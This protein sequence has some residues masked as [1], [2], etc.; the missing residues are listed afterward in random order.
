MEELQP[1]TMKIQE[2]HITSVI[3]APNGPDLVNKLLTMDFSLVYNHHVH[4]SL[5]KSAV[6][7]QWDGYE[8]TC[9]LKLWGHNAEYWWINDTHFIMIAKTQQIYMSRCSDY[10]DLLK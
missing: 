4:M 7:A 3:N 8:P 6:H 9:R 2:V 10:K 1:K 5:L